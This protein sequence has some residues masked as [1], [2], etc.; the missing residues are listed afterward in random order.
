MTRSYNMYCDS[1]LHAVIVD[2]P[3]GK[4]SYKIIEKLL[5]KIILLTSCSEINRVAIPLLGCST[6]GLDADRVMN[7]YIKR[8][9]DIPDTE[10]I[11]IK[12]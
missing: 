2:K 3:G 6:G 1:I 12:R 5:D 4:S 9:K 8:F 10:F 7:M 11:I